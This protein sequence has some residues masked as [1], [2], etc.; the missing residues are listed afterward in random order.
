MFDH[1]SEISDR[2]MQ[3]PKKTKTYEDFANVVRVCSVPLLG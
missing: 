3:P 1:F 2:S